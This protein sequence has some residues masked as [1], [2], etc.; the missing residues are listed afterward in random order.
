MITAI[1][2]TRLG[3]LLGAE[4]LRVDKSMRDL[5]RVVVLAGP[6]GSGKS[7]FLRFLK[8]CVGK[9]GSAPWKMLAEDPAFRRALM[10]HNAGGAERMVT[11]HGTF[12]LKDV[13]YYLSFE[14]LGAE[15][16]RPVAFELT[17][18]RSA[19]VD[20]GLRMTQAQSIEAMKKCE[21]PGLWNAYQY[22]WAYLLA[23]ARGL[24]FGDED[25]SV[26]EFSRILRALLG[27]ELGWNRDAANMPMPRLFGRPFNPDELSEGQKVL[28]AWAIS[29]HRQRRRLRHAVV[30]IDEPENHLHPDV[31][32]RA[33]QALRDEVLGDYGQIW[34]ATHSIPLIAWARID[35]LYA[36]ND[37]KI[38]YAGNNVCKVVDALAGG[39]E[40]REQLRTFLADAEQ[41]GLYHFIAQCLVEPSVVI[42]KENDPQEKSFAT[43][44]E[45]LLKENDALRILDYGAGRCRLAEAL[46]KAFSDKPD[47]LRR[48]QYLAYDRD[49]TFASE[50]QAR[51]NALCK[52]GALAEEVN[53]LDLR[54]KDEQVDLVVLCNVLHEIPAGEWAGVFRNCRQALKPTGSLIVI[55][56]QTP[57]VGELPHRKGFIILNCSEMKLLLQEDE[58]L[59]GDGI[60]GVRRG[61]NVV[62]DLSNNVPEDW[63]GR[64]SILQVPAASLNVENLNLDKA[65]GAVVDRCRDEVEKLRSDA[66]ASPMQRTGRLHALYAMMWMNAELAR[67][68]SVCR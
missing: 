58:E 49:T 17:L 43:V 7:R 57:S 29:L 21:E 38:E 48:I 39:S 4:G 11:P 62:I 32:I 3:V 6:N 1:D 64:I 2:F 31:C 9:L 10:Q 59:V 60:S 34:V 14:L 19:R 55:E 37:G 15:N 5:R 41:I 13:D 20:D 42:S 63:C 54:P 66:S 51:L 24:A 47:L 12:R 25:G 22:E 53:V 44:V 8:R 27:T 18:G 50:R 65:L 67:G 56:D 35:S 26:E 61:K 45:K 68:V 28:I 36:V 52:A 33:L 30:L 46:T 16:V 23:M 40:G